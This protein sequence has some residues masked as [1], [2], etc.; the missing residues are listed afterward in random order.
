MQFPRKQQ[1]DEFEDFLLTL[2]KKIKNRLLLC[3]QE[4][5]IKKTKN[6]ETSNRKKTPRGLPR[7]GTLPRLPPTRLQSK[8]M[9]KDG[10]ESTA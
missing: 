10:T 6:R 8:D 7:R 5:L 3:E 4:D 9:E 2:T 1:N